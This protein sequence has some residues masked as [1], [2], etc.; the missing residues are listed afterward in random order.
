[1]RMLGFPVKLSD[2]PCQVRRPAPELGAHNDEIFA[3]IGWRRPKQP[4]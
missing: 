3:E 1:V 2:T 4:D